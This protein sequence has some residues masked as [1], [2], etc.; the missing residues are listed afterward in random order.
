M[1][2]ISDH[3]GFDREE[4]AITHRADYPARPTRN[5]GLAENQTC[6]PY[7]KPP[8]LFLAH[9]NP[10]LHEEEE[11]SPTMPPMGILGIEILPPRP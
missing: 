4:Y 10:P 5:Y 11:P 8:H 7:V 9:P 2:K 1:E 3:P 6:F